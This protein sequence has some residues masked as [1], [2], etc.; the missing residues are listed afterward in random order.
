MKKIIAI[1][2]ALQEIIQSPGRIHDLFVRRPGT[3]FSGQADRQG[4]CCWTICADP[5]EPDFFMQLQIVRSALPKEEIVPFPAN[6]SEA[7]F[8]AEDLKYLCRMPLR[9]DRRIRSGPGGFFPYRAPLTKCAFC[10]KHPDH[11]GSR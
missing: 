5:D 8:R 6:L 11:P 2:W 9:S 3:G 10:N 7:G 4:R 1:R